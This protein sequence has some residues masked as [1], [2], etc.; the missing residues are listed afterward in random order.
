MY[1]RV[2][3]HELDHLLAHPESLASLELRAALDDGR[4]LDLGR[5]WEPL[6]V[7]IDGGVHLPDTGPTLGDEPLPD[8]DPGAAWSC[9][10]AARVAAV[11]E[12]LRRHH[13]QFARL[14]VV[15]GE[16]TDPYMMDTRTGG[17]QGNRDYLV[18]KLAR[19]AEHY[20]EAA[21]HREAMLVRIGTRP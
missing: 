15:D 3:A 5:A 9:V 4:A 17:Y 10:P 2:P 13:R 19:L 6:A 14:Y 12:E 8:L 21:R 11:A 7:L 1:L 20:D 16:D 18:A